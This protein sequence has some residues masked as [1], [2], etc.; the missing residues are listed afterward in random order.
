[1]WDTHNYQEP[2]FFLESFNYF[3]NWQEQTNNSNVTV[4]IG[5]YS[6]YSVDNPSGIVNYS[7]PA[8]EHIPYPRLLSAIAE[9]VYLLGAE[10][11]PNTVKMTTYAPSF[12]NLNAPNWTPN[13]VDFTASPLNTTKSVSWYSQS[14]LAHY[15]GTETLPVINSQ[16]DFNP[17]WWVATIDTPSNAVYLKVRFLIPLDAPLT[18]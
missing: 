6:V 15:R 1:M 16:G 17:L 18:M 9:S 2:S 12:A 13:L 4:L 14:L 3:D 11:N 7:N 5:E 10:R 8:S